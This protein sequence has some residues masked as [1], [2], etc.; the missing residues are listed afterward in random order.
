VNHDYVGKV[1]VDTVP[2]RPETFYHHSSRVEGAEPWKWIGGSGMVGLHS[3]R[4]PLYG[5]DTARPFAVRL[6]FAEPEHTR[7]RNRVFSVA[8]DGQE[9]LKDFDIFRESGGRLRTVVKEYPAVRYSGRKTGSLPAIEL[10]FKA[11][12]GEPL[13]CGIEVNQVE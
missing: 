11:S 5:I 3:A 13:I 10:T 6:C 9:I 1:M 2:E 7:P 12:A 8:L 4:V